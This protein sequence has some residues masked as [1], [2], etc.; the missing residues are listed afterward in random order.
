MKKLL[1]VVL[2]TIAIAIYMHAVYGQETATQPPAKQPT[3]EE[4]QWQAMYLNE[5]IQNLQ[6]DFATSKQRLQ[7]VQAKIKAMQPAKIDAPAKP[8]EDK[9]PEPKKK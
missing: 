9:K 1:V 6:Y 3:L 7:E 8:A 4:L 5:R 2:T